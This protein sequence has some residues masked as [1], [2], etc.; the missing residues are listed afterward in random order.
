MFNAYTTIFFSPQSSQISRK[1]ASVPHIVVHTPVSNSDINNAS[2]KCRWLQ[3]GIDSG[4]CH[5]CPIICTQAKHESKFSHFSHSRNWEMLLAFCAQF[6][7]TIYILIMARRTAPTYTASEWLEQQ[8]TH[9]IAKSVFSQ[10]EQSTLHRAHTHTYRHTS[11][12]FQIR[13]IILK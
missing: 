8:K 2:E 1:Q 9:S 10:S 11:P 7:V 4:C 5:S 13:F 6:R 12:R 3:F